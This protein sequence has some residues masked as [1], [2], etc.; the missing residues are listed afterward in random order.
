[1]RPF[2]F[3]A[4]VG[5]CLIWAANAILSR[6]V[7][8]VAGIPPIFLSSARFMLA[9]IVLLPFLHPLPRPITPVIITGLLMGAG[10]F[11]LLLSGY[12]LISAS[13]AA[14]LL[15]TGVPMTA[16]LSALILRE[17]IGWRRVLG[18]AVALTGV[19]VVLWRPGEMSAGLGS[20]LVL[21]AAASLALGSVLLKRLRGITP[22]RMQ[23]WTAT[24]SILPL[25]LG[26]ATL[27]H[28]QFEKV[29][30]NA[31][32][33]IGLLLFSALVVTVISH[34]AYYRLLR[35]YDASIVSSLTLMFPLITVALGIATLGETTTSN[36]WVGAALAIAGVAV[37]LSRPKRP[38]A[39]AS[40]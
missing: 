27:E 13:L 19:V 8:A 7:I 1:M 31:V 40:G 33:F 36:F 14:I 32:A 21:A 11:G 22:L 18:I 35:L 17:R 10:H 38:V 23:A 28:G 25:L 5:I 9:A 39:I 37:I 34:T 15:Q 12:G 2:D 4:M 30:T 16:I 20:G 24:T 26:S 6:Y 3:L 29:E